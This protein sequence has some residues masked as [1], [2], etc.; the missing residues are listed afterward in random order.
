MHKAE[1]PQVV[2]DSFIQTT[3]TPVQP[4]AV[5]PGGYGLSMKHY[6]YR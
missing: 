4:S 3:S 6:Q 2:S 5:V 1:C